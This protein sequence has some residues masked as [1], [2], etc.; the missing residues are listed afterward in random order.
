[1]AN[2]A[3]AYDKKEKPY[4]PSMF[5]ISLIAA[6]RMNRII[7]LPANHYTNKKGL[8][9]ALAFAKPKGVCGFRT[10]FPE[11]FL[12]HGTRYGILLAN[13]W[14][15]K[16]DITLETPES[17]KHYLEG[18]VHKSDVL[19]FEEMGRIYGESAKKYLTEL[20][21]RY[22]RTWQGAVHGFL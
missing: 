16:Y 12:S 15:N 4:S 3:C 2:M 20:R 17:A 7:S 6:L 9:D 11:Q 19:L 13:S 22:Y 21:V 8:D 14:D 5:S 18:I 1:M 10:L